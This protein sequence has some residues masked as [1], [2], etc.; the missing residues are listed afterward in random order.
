[1]GKTQEII[2]PDSLKELFLFNPKMVYLNHGSFGACPK[3][4]FQVYQ[5]FQRELEFSPV[6]FI[7]EKGRSYLQDSKEALAQFVGANSVDLFFTPNPTYAM[8]LVAKSGWLKK[9]DEILSTNLEYGAL[10]KMW[11]YV[12][13]SIGAKYVQQEITLPIIDHKHTVEAFFEGYTSNTKAIFISHMTSST[14]MILPIEEICS[15]AKKRGL[16]TIVDGAHVP[17]HIPLDLNKLNVDVYTGA[18]HKWMLTPKGSSFLWVNPSF[19]QFIEPLIV[20]WGYDENLN[21]SE[22]FN[23]FHQFVGTDDFSAYLT[24]PKSLEFRKNYNWE[25]KIVTSKALA[26]KYYP[27]I[28]ATLNTNLLH[29]NEEEYAGQMRSVRIKCKNPLEFKKLLF[30]K[31]NI[32]I[33]IMELGADHFIRYSVQGYTEES[34]LEYLNEVL[35]KEIKTGQILL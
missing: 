29:P 15:E 27:I 14:G 7:V 20:S 6:E 11:K 2:G 24:L 12:C 19:Q 35:Q 16:I 32:E 31:Y 18:C 23:S 9:G 21:N 33:P 3:E 8:N 34:E 28:C 22:G 4:V 30:Q 17:G 26:Q 5:D 13:N 10:D 1:M 25:E